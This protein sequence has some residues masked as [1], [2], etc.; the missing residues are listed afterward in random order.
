[1]SLEV[2]PEAVDKYALARIREIGINRVNFG[3]QSTSEIERKL[4]RR[5]RNSSYVLSIVD[6]ALSLGFSNVC[7]DL[8]YGLADQTDQSFRESVISVAKLRPQT[9]CAYAL[10]SRPHTGY[11]ADKFGGTSSEVL[12]HRYD[13][14]RELLKELGYFQE[15]HV[16]YVRD[17]RGGYLQKRN[18]WRGDNIVGFG[19]GARSYYRYCDIRSG[20]SLRD[21]RRT[22]NAYLG[23]DSSDHVRANGILLDR[24]EQMRR[25][26]ILG[27]FDL[28]VESFT[29]QFGI[30][31]QQHFGDEFAFLERK[32][33]IT[34][35]AGSVRL[36]D[37]GRTYRDN[38]AQYLFSDQVREAV[39]SYR[40]DD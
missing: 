8:I 27:L 5:N 29:V 33:L 15:N 6:E 23:N 21:R 20:Y 12:Y 16:R 11:S 22:L 4:S 1:V 10:T 26:V 9:V 18:H 31:P 17:A 36:T 3:V 32:G 14:A 37:R 38:V 19:A 13:Q 39:M 28:D 35:A 2:S 7:V 34:I 24:E 25:S 40:Y 30:A